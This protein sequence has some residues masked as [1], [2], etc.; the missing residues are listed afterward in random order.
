[1]NF[2]E[3]DEAAQ[4]GIYV[5]DEK[6]KELIIQAFRKS[7]SS[8]LLRTQQRVELTNETITNFA[9]YHPD[10]ERSVRCQLCGVRRFGTNYRLERT[11]NR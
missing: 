7:I 4:I 10:Y 2:V 1:M 6:G 9:N 8:S 3:D 11:R 5:W